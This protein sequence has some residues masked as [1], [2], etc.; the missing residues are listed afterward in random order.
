MNGLGLVLVLAWM[1]AGPMEENLLVNPDFD[2]DLGGWPEVSGTT[3]ASLDANTSPSS[4]S[5]RVMVDS[6]PFN[7]VGIRQC[8]PILPGGT[9]S[10]TAAGLF[11]SGQPADD[12]FRLSAELFWW[13]GPGCAE[14]SS[15]ATGMTVDVPQDGQ[16]HVLDFGRVTAPLWAAS[17]EIGGGAFRQDESLEPI[18]HFDQFVFTGPEVIF[19]DTFE[20]GFLDGWSAVVP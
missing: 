8:V 14:G 6:P 15:T 9:Y 20:S 3:W 7:S 16:W 2:T 12:S 17:A 13:D 10:L 18:V 5:A 11:P 19:T 1:A 4:G